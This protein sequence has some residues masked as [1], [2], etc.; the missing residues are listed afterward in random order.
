MEIEFYVNDL[1]TPPTADFH[2]FQSTVA[3]W[4]GKGVECRTALL[5]A[6][7][8]GKIKHNKIIAAAD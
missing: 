2:R 8:N 3:L 4:E 1:Q 6:Y 5:R 7:V